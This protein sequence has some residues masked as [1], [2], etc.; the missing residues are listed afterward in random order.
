[1]ETYSRRENLKFFGVPENTKRTMVEGSSEQ[2]VMVENTR[3]VVYQFLEEKLKI[4]Q[5]REKTEF[6]R[7]HRLGEPNSF[8]PHSI[9]ARFL[10]YSDRELVMANACKHLKSNQDFQ[11]FEDI[12]KDLYELRKQQMQKCKEARERGCKAYF[13]KANLDTLFVNGKY[14]APDQ[15]LQ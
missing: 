3:E 6:Q 8:K 10:Q 11:V 15:P 5:P 2:R 13:S 9:I 7:I 4:E 1:M 14:V 12:A